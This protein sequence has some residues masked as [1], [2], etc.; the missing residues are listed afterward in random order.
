MFQKSITYGDFVAFFG[1]N[2]QSKDSFRRIFE[3]VEDDRRVREG[4]CF[5]LVLHLI[6]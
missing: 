3:T 1:A 2:Q 4:L 5:H 6:L